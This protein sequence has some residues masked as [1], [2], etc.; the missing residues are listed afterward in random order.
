[1]ETI[2]QIDR[3]ILDWIQENLRYDFLDEIFTFIT[4]LGNAGMIWI[5]VGI[6]LCCFKKWRKGGMT[7]LIAVAMAFLVGEMTI[8]PLV[9][10]VRPFVYNPTLPLL[11]EPPNGFSFPSGHAMSSFA[12]AT[13]LFLCGNRRKSWSWF[14]GAA[15]IAFSR[16]Y[17]YVH[18]PSDVLLGSI[19]G[20]LSG[21]A[22]FYLV[23]KLWQ[24]KTWL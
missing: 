18:Y 9:G 10:R 16:V 17:L 6:F 1:M 19:F 22:A 11:I 2:L 14:L 5:A 21:M 3:S 12:A 15:L 8:K 20:I 4:K 13:A 7:M 24:R 23:K